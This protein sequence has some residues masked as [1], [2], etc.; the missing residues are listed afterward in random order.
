MI[1][2]REFRCWVLFR[3]AM[4]RVGTL[5][6]FRGSEHSAVMFQCCICAKTISVSQKDMRWF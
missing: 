1:W 6:H 2:L 5:T 3:H 4:E